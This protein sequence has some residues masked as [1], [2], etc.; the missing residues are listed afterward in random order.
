MWLNF[1]QQNWNLCFSSAR[2]SHIF[3]IIYFIIFCIIF[4][5]EFK[6]CVALNALIRVKKKSKF[7]TFSNFLILWDRDHFNRVHVTQSRC[8]CLIPHAFEKF[9]DLICT[10]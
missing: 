9:Y 10:L 8:R 6:Q 2:S 4:K 3:I 7:V 5:I 1:C